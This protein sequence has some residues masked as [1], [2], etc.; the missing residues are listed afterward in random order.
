MVE[1]CHNLAC[2]WQGSVDDYLRLHAQ[3]HHL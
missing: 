2:C 3:T 1:A